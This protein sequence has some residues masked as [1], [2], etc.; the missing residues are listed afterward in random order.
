MVTVQEVSDVEIAFGGNMK[1][2]LPDYH[3]IPEEFRNDRT[4]WNKVFADWFYC[5]LKMLSGLQK[6]ESIPKRLSVT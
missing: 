1:N 3:S 2:L 5:G 4:K 6:K